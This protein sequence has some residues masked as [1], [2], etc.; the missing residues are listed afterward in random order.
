[1]E[2]IPDEM[3]Y[4]NGTTPYPTT[5]SVWLD[6]LEKAEFTVEIA[7]YY[8]ELRDGTAE[9]FPTGDRVFGLFYIISFL[10]L[11]SVNTFMACTAL[12]KLIKHFY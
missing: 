7:S 12:L 3:S 6:L 2:S 5:Y 4:R 1:M 10:T 11:K 9:N 8:W